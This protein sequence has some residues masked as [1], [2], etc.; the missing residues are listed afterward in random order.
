MMTRENN[1]GVRVRI[2]PSPTGFMHIGTAR[3]A[4]FNLLFAKKNGGKFIL[5]IEDTDR[6]RSTK[7]FEKDIINGLTWLNLVWDE[8]PDIGGPFGPYRQS[9]RGAIYAKYIHHLLEKNLAYYCF[10]TEEALEAER[11]AMLADGRAPKYSGTCRNLAEAEIARNHNEGKQSVIRFR[12]PLEKITVDDLVRGKTIFNMS[13]VGD[14]VIARTPETPL[15][16]FAVVVDDYEMKIS[17]VM[18]GEEHFANTP[19]QIAIGEALGFPKPKFGHIPLILNPDRSKMSKRFGATSVEEYKKDGYLPGA[20]INFLALLGWHPLPEVDRETGKVVEREIFTIDELVSK[21]D[22]ERVQKGGAAFNAEKLDWL[23][24]QYLKRLSVDEFINAIREVT[25]IPANVEEK[26]LKAIIE[27]VRD[28][29]KKLSD[30]NDLTPFFFARPEY[31]V[32]ML[33]WENT[34]QNAIRENLTATRN[35]IAAVNQDTL[36]KETLEA[37]LTPI[38]KARGRGETFWPLRV[39]LSGR[40]ASPGP[41]EIMMILGHTETLARIDTAI[42]KLKEIS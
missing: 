9:E 4:L 38:A 25:K 19:K 30:F 35:A 37:T 6:E 40:D 22:I 7:E 29:V 20:L 11:Q 16:N 10:C 14:I 12:M 5:R 21:F 18:R 3:T 13:L 17:H 8:G 27:L 39:A 1:H 23:N 32:T 33:L 26:T 28:R 42:E 24:A 41:L 36:T 2:A 34:P 31:P 15:F